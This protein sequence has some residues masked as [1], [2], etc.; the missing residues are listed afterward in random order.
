MQNYWFINVLPWWLS[1]VFGWKHTILIEKGRTRF[2]PNFIYFRLL[3]NNEDKNANICTTMVFLRVSACTQAAKLG[4]CKTVRHYFWH[5]F[6]VRSSE[7]LFSSFK[8]MNW[9]CC[10][11]FQPLLER[12]IK[13][14]FNLNTPSRF[15]HPKRMVVFLKM[16]LCDH[17]RY[18]K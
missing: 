12:R 1:T 17:Q 3:F 18:L 9:D 2:G 13:S 6:R 4:A 7:L 15:I 11:N 10:C 5:E 16:S 8:A 14:E